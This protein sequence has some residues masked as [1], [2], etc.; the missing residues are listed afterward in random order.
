MTYED[1]ES[2]VET[3]NILAN[4]DTRKALAEAEEDLAMGR[5]LTL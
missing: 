1:Y 3:L 2:L 5:L 4:P